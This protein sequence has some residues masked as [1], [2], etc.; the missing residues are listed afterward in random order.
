MN[1]K[2]R[3]GQVSFPTL[4]VGASNLVGDGLSCETLVDFVLD[5]FFPRRAI[6]ELV[7][8]MSDRLL[9]SELPVIEKRPVRDQIPV[10]PVDHKYHLLDTFD[11]LF[12]LE[13]ARI[14]AL[15]LSGVGRKSH[16]SD[17]EAVPISQR[18]LVD[19]E[20]ATLPFPFVAQRLARE[21]PSRVCDDRA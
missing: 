6:Q 8:G 15:G 21:R 14:R 5:D 11:R 13:E 4:W 2:Q 16:R 10:V 1:R 19:A 7:N 20:S 9:F 12:V 17:D 18:F 3:H